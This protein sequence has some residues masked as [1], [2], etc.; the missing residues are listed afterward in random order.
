[1]TA[2]LICEGCGRP[3]AERDVHCTACG[4]ELP[5]RRDEVEGRESDPAPRGWLLAAGA[6]GEGG[7]FEPMPMVTLTM[8]DGPGWRVRAAS[9]SAS[10]AAPMAPIEAPVSTVAPLPA[11]SQAS[12][13]AAGSGTA[14]APAADLRPLRR[15]YAPLLA[16]VLLSSAGAIA[17]LAL[18]V[19]LHR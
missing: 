5:G 18:H 9:A 15:L 17:L 4:R 3:P 10:L 2:A 13:S 7:V 6:R 11:P 14:A 1:M 16:L 19:L 8:P 12:P